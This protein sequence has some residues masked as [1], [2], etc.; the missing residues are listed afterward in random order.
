MKK[1]SII[2]IDSNELDTLVHE[3]LGF[4]EYEF[5]P[6]EECGNDSSHEFTVSNKPHD[7]WQQES[8]DKWAKYK[9]VRYSNGAILNELCI[10]GFI[11][12]GEYLVTVCW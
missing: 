10:K 7:K 12:P 5:V 11:E 3:K 2:E 4:K 9:F 8:I 6:V 1:K